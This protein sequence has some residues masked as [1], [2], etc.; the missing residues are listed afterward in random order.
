MKKLTVLACQSVVPK[1]FVSLVWYVYECYYSTTLYTKH[2][3]YHITKS[4]TGQEGM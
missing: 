3:S 4:R 1:V 2:G